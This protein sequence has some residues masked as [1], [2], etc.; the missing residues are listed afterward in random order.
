MPKFRDFFARSQPL[1]GLQA[2]L[3]SEMRVSVYIKPKKLRN[4]NLNVGA[5]ATVV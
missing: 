2:E 1:L 5:G 3:W 4:V